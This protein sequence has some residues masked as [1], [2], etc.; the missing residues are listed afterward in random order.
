MIRKIGTKRYYAGGG[1]WYSRSVGM[2]WWN[3]D[4][5]KRAYKI[6]ERLRTNNQ[7]EIVKFEYK[8]MKHDTT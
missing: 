4:G 5:L 1:H 7:C 2:I 3:D 6:F 8:E